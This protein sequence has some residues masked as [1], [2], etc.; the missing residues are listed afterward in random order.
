M[1]LAINLFLAFYIVPIVA[2]YIMMQLAHKYIWIGVSPDAS[3]VALVLIP[4]I[5]MCGTIYLFCALVKH[6]Y[7]KKQ[8]AK[9]KEVRTFSQAFFRWREKE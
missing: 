1:W 5:N 4:L 9:G 2:A 7:K 8:K 6:F 3:D